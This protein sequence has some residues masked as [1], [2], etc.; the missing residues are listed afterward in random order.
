MGLGSDLHSHRQLKEAPL[1]TFFLT[2]VVSAIG[3][4]A[5][6]VAIWRLATAFV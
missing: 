3:L 5:A 6:H 1:R 4:L 2:V